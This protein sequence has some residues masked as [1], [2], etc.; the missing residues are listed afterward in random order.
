MVTLNYVSSKNWLRASTQVKACITESPAKVYFSI[1]Y[2]C[3]M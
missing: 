2:K 1:T 3:K